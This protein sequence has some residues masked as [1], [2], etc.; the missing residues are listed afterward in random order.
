MPVS[1]LGLAPNPQFVRPG[2]IDLTGVWHFAFDDADAGLAER[3][4]ENP[5]RFG[6]R[7]T[8]P[9]PPESRLSGVH[10]TGFHPWLWYA[11]SFEAP[12]LATGER[13]RLCLGAVD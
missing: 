13:L 12:Q 3:W 11:R 5:E 2:W 4:H 9:Y 8:L 1:S 7:I 6:E 10:E